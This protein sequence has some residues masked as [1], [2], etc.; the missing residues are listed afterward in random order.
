MEESLSTTEPLRIGELAAVVGV[1]V[2]TVRYYEQLGLLRPS[3]STPGGFRLYSEGDL[4]R[5]RLIQRFKELGFT[6]EEIRTVLD[7]GHEPLRDREGR[8][9]FSEKVLAGE[10]AAI[11]GKIQSFQEQKRQIETAL[12]A[13]RTC[14]KCTVV[15]CA[16]ACDKRKAF[17]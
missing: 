8:I 2:R 10:L 17:V 5:L 4:R 7:A 1:T 12:E 13:L 15:P 9:A 14:R 16:P 6:L 3:A 11:D